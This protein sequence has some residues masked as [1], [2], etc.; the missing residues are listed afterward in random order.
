MNFSARFRSVVG[1]LAVQPVIKLGHI[2]S[3]NSSEDV[4]TAGANS[5]AP[6]LVFLNLLKTDAQNL[7]DI[8]LGEP[9][10]HAPPPY[11]SPDVGI[12]LF[13]LKVSWQSTPRLSDFHADGCCARCGVG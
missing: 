10:E 7:P 9:R 2:C 8:V 1:K 5:V 11:L 6:V 4:H 12:N 13:G 3:E